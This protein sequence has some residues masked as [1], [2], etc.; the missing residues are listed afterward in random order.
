MQIHSFNITN[1][2]NIPEAWCHGVFSMLDAR[3]R[4][5]SSRDIFYMYFS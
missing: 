4:L 2:R 1:K 5:V 3:N